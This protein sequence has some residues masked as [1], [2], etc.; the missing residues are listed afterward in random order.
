MNKKPNFTI[1]W[2]QDVYDSVHERN[3]DCI[4]AF[5]GKRRKG[6]SVSALGFC[7]SMD[8]EGFTPENLAERCFIHPLK[9]IEWARKPKK[10]IYQGL[11]LMFDEAGVG[12]PSR[13]WQSFNNK[14]LFKV[15]Q[16]F[17]HKNFIVS[18]TLPNL[19]FMDAGPRSLMDYVV[20]CLKVD[21]KRAMNICKVKEIYVDPVTG[22]WRTPFLRYK[23]DNKWYKFSKP[24]E[25]KRC[26]LKL[27]KAYEKLQER[28]KQ[29]FEDVI[30]SE[31]QQINQDIKDKVR[32]KGINE[33]ELVEKVI[34]DKDEY[35]KMRA[36]KWIVDQHLLEYEFKVGRGIAG[37]VKKVS[38]KILNKDAI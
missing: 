23:V 36:G 33:H 8:P 5:I 9:F 12:I 14:A 17:G 22:G 7:E 6:K 27:L 11:A 26:S 20:T 32:K 25:F 3:E 10:E 16:V 34:Q 19:G 4:A 15:M 21:R 1:P 37:R 35:A 13:E 30:Y 2:K 38:E 29:E 18:F 31:A 28:Y 24:I